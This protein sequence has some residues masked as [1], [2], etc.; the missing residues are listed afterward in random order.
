MHSKEILTS[1][2]QI[3]W[4]LHCENSLNPWIFVSEFPTSYLNIVIYI[5][6]FYKRQFLALTTPI[7]NAY[8]S[9]VYLLYSLYVYAFRM[10]TVFFCFLEFSFVNGICCRR[11]HKK[12]ILTWA[13][14]LVII[15]SCLPILGQSPSNN[16]P[17]I[18]FIRTIN[19]SFVINYCS[20]ER[21]VHPNF[22]S[23]YAD[24]Q[25]DFILSN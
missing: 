23:N 5:I 15:C 7:L 14:R 13:G 11:W 25:F 16:Y 12:V 1:H 2:L 6:L 8:C 4:K 18:T 20:C 10:T 17:S 19:T 24:L 21:K 3:F 22:S 9:T